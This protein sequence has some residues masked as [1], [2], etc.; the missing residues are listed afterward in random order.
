MPTREILPQF[1][2]DWARL[3][4]EQRAAFLLAVDKLIAD[5]RA[6][7]GLRAGLRVK[8]VRGSPGAY[9]LTWA[10]DGRATFSYGRS[11]VGDEPHIIWRRIGTHAILRAP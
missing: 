10:P 6:G 2:G 1:W 8:G 11:V 9:E 7:T 4:A 5:L 3:T